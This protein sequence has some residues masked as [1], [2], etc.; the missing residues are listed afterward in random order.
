MAS[1]YLMSCW[2]VNVVLSRCTAEREDIRH[3]NSFL[4]ST[5]SLHFFRKL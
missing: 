5:L 2:S 3:L 4:V 1:N